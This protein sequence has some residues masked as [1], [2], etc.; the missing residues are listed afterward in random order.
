MSHTDRDDLRVQL[1]QHLESNRS[2][3]VGRYQQALRE[4]LFS[5][6]ATVRP[7]MLKK[8]AADEAEAFANFLRQPQLQTTERGIQLYQAGLSV[9]SVL[10]LHQTTR[11]FFVTHINN[12]QIGPAL[13]VIDIYQEQIVQGFIQS[14]EKAVFSEQERT[15]HAFERVVNREKP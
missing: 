14:L 15:R 7:R 10:R 5:S 6:R 2:D 8:V 9:L 12:E 4:T 1:G 11:Q 3:L 13:A